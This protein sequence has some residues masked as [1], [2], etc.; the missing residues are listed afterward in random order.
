[1]VSVA[2]KAVASVDLESDTSFLGLGKQSNAALW[3]SS[4]P[5]LQPRLR[6]TN[7]LQPQASFKV[8]VLEA[9]G[10]IGQPHSLLVKM[11]PLVSALHLYDT[12]NVKS[13]SCY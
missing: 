7:Q 9:A 5:K 1:M 2:S 4:L 13:S 12:A 11:S 8:A 10:G 6:A 3:A